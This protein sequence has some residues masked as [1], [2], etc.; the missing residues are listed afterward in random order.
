VRL[1]DGQWQVVVVRTD[2]DKEKWE[3]R[4]CELMEDVVSG[5]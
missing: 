4:G 1:I 5:Y 2:E 3:A